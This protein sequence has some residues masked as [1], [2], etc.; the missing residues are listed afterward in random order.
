MILFE[1]FEGLVAVADGHA[2]AVRV[3]KQASRPFPFLVNL[4]LR[5]HCNTTGVKK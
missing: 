1:M 4:V 2:R 5:F 3:A